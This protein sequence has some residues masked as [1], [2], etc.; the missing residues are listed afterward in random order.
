M[1]IDKVKKL[2]AIE[3]LPCVGKTSVARALTD[4]FPHS[5]SAVS[6]LLLPSEPPESTDQ[7]IYYINDALKSSRATTDRS[8][9]ILDRYYFS[10]IAYEMALLADVSQNRALLKSSENW[11]MK[12]RQP[13][14]VV[15]IKEDHDKAYA[16]TM[17][18]RPHAKGLWGEREGQ[19]RMAI[20]LEEVIQHYSHRV[21][22]KLVT[23]TSNADIGQQARILWKILSTS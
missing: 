19:A 16:R 1:I 7:S 6:E 2:V 13:T 11:A 15:M 17:E 23:L 5:V 3:G 10:T 18:F 9:C 21:K 22:Y 20:C 8:I 12:L 14:H 4:L